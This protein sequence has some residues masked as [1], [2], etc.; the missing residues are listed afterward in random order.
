MCR[1]CIH[2]ANKCYNATIVAILTFMSRINFMLY[3]VKVPCTEFRC[4]NC[5]VI[6]CC[7]SIQYMYNVLP[8]KSDS[9]VM[10]CLQSYQGLII[11]RSLVY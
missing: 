11:D 9:D 7:K 8:T 5:N 6:A 10:L 1:C 4:F 2:P 3:G